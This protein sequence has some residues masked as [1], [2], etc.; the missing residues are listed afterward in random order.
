[1]RP[2]EYVRMHRLERDHWWFEGKRGVVESLLSRAGIGAPSPDEVVLDVGC[3]T[4]AALEAFGC[5]AVPVGMDDHREALRFVDRDLVRRV[6]GRA[7]RLPFRSSS[8]DRV[9]LLDVAEHVGDDEAVFRE[10]RRVLRRSGF[11]IVHVPAHPALWSGHDE[12]MHHVRRYRRSELEAKLGRGG[13]EPIVLTWTFAGILVPAAVVRTARRRSGSA[14]FDSV[15]RWLDPWL[16]MLQKLETAWLRRA[17]LPFGLSLGA[18][19]RSSDSV[20]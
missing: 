1:M 20:S 4:G 6:Q 18:L 17:D 10:I 2:D 7:T 3:G 13:L 11:A 19:V 5:P 12:A 9:F 16:R 14:D 8:V 15:P